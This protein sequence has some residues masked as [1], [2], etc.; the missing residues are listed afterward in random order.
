MMPSHLSDDRLI[1]VCLLES[2]SMAEQQ[3]IASC[4]SCDARRARLQSLMNDVAGT[5]ATAADAAFPAD[6]PTHLG[7]EPRSLAPDRS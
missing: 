7:T 1:E 5:A 2:P 6:R 4:A 3:H